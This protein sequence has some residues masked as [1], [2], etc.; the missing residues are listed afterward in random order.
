LTTAVGMFVAEGIV[1][2]RMPEALRRQSIDWLCLALE[3]EQVLSVP[4][5]SSALEAHA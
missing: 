2:H 5:A 1:C 4:Q 3:G